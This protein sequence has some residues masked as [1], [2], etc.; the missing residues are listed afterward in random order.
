MNIPVAIV[1]LGFYFMGVAE[2]RKSGNVRGRIGTISLYL[3]AATF[4]LSL[5]G[6]ACC[7]FMLG[8]GGLLGRLIE[9]VQRSKG[10]DGL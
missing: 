4:I 1:L 2:G 3:L 5:Q 7:L 10:K 8:F 9:T 6:L